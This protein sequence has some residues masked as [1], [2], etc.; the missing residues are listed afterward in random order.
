M[1]R[2]QFKYA[3]HR[4][5][6]RCLASLFRC[7]WV[8]NFRRQVLRMFPY[9]RMESQATD[10]IYMSWLVDI[11]KVRAR[12]P[13]PLKLWEK[14][15][16]TIFSILF[17]HHHDFG[18]HRLGPLRKCFGSPKLSNWRFYLAADK[19]KH[20]IVFEQIMSDSLFYVISGRLFSDA[21]P[22]QYDPRFKLQL[23]QMQQQLNIQAKIHIDERYHLDV[24]LKQ[25]SG[26]QLPE[27]WKAFFPTWQEALQFLVPQQHI[28]LESADQSPQL[29]QADIRID[30]DFES[31]KALT[32]EQL[33]CPLLQELEIDLDVPALCFYIPALDF[34]VLNETCE[35]PNLAGDQV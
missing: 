23:Q 20:G 27:Q 14:D 6:F 28:L 31:I 30:A 34:H 33:D 19:I 13:E 16:K 21:M 25:A 17:Y 8:L 12:F 3:Q 26:Q 2:H 9:L 18:P 11:D 32:I 5:L 35:I 7:R 15:G 29:A 1:W 10:T 24:G 4:L 22:A